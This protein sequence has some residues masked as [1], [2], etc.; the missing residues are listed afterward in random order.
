MLQSVTDATN[1]VI[2]VAIGHTNQRGVPCCYVFDPEELFLYFMSRMKSGNDHTTM[3][4]VLVV[5]Q[6]DGLML[7]AGF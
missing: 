4:H 5:V 2:R 6:R 7:G 3:S 1:G